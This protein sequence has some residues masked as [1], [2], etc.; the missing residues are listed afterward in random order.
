M[1]FRDVA[2]LAVP[3]SVRWRPVE[4]VGLEH[5]T[6]AT[7]QAGIRAEAVAIGERAEPRY[8]V[9]YRIDCTADFAVTDFAVATTDGRQLAM[10]RRGGRWHDAA[11][12][13]LPTFDDCIDIDLQGSPFT[14]TLPIRRERWEVGQSR[15]FAMLYIPFDDFVPIIDRQIYTCLAP[16][17]F[18][19]QAAD[20]SFEAELPVD[21]DGLVVDYPSLFE[22]IR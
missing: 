18:R 3:R 9:S 19:Y 8:G 10:E 11:G 6:L 1:S 22:R 4:G 2:L 14:N 17:L 16:R 13:A 21:E 20:R 7:T 5:L 12:T 15:E